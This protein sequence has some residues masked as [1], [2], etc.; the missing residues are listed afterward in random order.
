MLIRYASLITA[1]V[2]LNAHLGA[3]LAIDP[4]NRWLIRDFHN[5]VF[6]VGEAA[7]MDWNGHYAWGDPGAPSP[8]W[9]EATRQRVSLYRTLAGVPMEVELDPYL[10][11]AAQQAALMM[12]VRN[13]ISH[14]P[15]TWWQWY[16]EDAGLAARRSNLARGSTGPQAV[17]GYMMDFGANNAS[18]GHRRWLLLPQLEVIGNGDVPGSPSPSYSP[19]NVMWVIPESL[20]PRPATRD[21]FIAWP[22]RGYIPADLVYARWS[23]SLPGADFTNAV[24]HMESGGQGI[25]LYIESRDADSGG[26]IGD[27]TLVWVPDNLSTSGR[28]NWPRPVWDQTVQVTVSRVD[29]DGSEH[30]FSYSVTIFDPDRPGPEEYPTRAYTEEPVIPTVPAAFGVDSREWAEAIQGRLIMGEAYSVLHDAEAGL[31]AFTAEVSSGFQLVQQDR[32]ASGAAAY[33]LANPDGDAQILRLEE[34]FIIGEGSPTLS[35]DSSLAWA[36]ANQVASVDMNLGSGDEWQT[37][38]S[39]RGPVQTNGEFEPVVIDLSAWSGKSARFR[40]RYDLEG[41]QYYYNSGPPFGWAFD[42][43]S[44][45]GVSR[46]TR[47][48]VLP[49]QENRSMMTLTFE[50]DSPAFLQVR[51]IAFGGQPLSWG[52]ITPI[53]PVPCES[54]ACETGSWIEDPLFGW[55]HAADADWT[56]FENL[57]WAYVSEFPWIRINGKWMCYVRGSMRDGLWIYHEDFGY[58]YTHSDLGDLVHYAPFDEDSWGRL[59]Q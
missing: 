16:T 8:E 53:T 6:S 37:I 15:D 31:G 3:D 4:D 47:I 46:I 29:I 24:V 57:G 43:L 39:T 50:N 48:E 13:Q 41:G 33:H 27:P 49:E 59:S 20:G 25:P 28:V 12:S 44:L 22:P 34:E 2:G 42:N 58:A 19:V 36:T 7:S 18:V 55:N 52:P 32:V 14:T 21:P 40:L 17:E 26:I 10:S 9:Q 30:F 11:A 45:S 38:W 51:D 56:Y 35:F 54:V 5:T 23:F 1:L